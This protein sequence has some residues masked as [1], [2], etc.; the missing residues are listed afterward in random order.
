MTDNAR[1]KGPKARLGHVIATQV[2]LTE[3]H[4]WRLNRL[5]DHYETNKSE[6]MRRL[7]DRDYERIEEEKSEAGA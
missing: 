3:E 4:D 1:P 2:R 5:A 6:V 7:I